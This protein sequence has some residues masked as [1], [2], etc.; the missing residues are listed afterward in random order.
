M[1]TSSSNEIRLTLPDS[2]AAIRLP[3][4]WSPL[5]QS[6]PLVTLLSPEGDLRVAFATLPTAAGTPEEIAFQTWRLFDASFAF[7]LLRKLQMPGSNGW[8]AVFQIF[9]DVPAARASTAWA[10]LRTLHDK[11]FI[12][13]IQGA[14]ASLSRR[15]AQISD[16]MEQWKPD[17]LSP[18]SLA[19]SPRR[20]WDEKLS[21]EL[22][23]FL[24]SAMT[25]RN[26]PGAALAVVQRG[27]IVFAEGF[28]SL[29]IASDAQVRPDTRFM[30]GSS[31][32]PLTTL[33]MA[34]LVAEG[35]FE[36]S[37]PVTQ[38]LPD[39]ALADAE[40]TRRLQMWHTVSASTGMPRRDLDL[41]FKFKGVTPE[42]RLAEMKEMKPTTGFGET[43]QY[44]NYLVGAG[45][46][47]AARSF[48]QQ[49]SLQEAYEQAMRE[50]VFEP[51]GMNRTTLE[52]E[53]EGVA[54]PHA[55]DFDGDVASL[56]PAIER[57][58][59]PI[60]PSGAVWST[61]IDMAQYLLLELNAG[62][63]R[64]GEQFLSAQALQKRWSGGARINDKASYGLGLL[65]SEYDGLDVMSHGGNTLGFSSD[66]YFLPKEEMG[67]VLLTNLGMANL[68]LEAARQKLFELLFDSP[69]KAERM[70]A[71]ASQAR[72]E[73]VTE[74]RAR[75]K[76]DAAS[77]ARLDM[78]TGEYESQELGPLRVRRKNGEYWAEFAS[79]SSASGLE[80]QPNGAML[81]VLT[82]APWGMGTLKLQVADEGRTL[83]L[84]GG[85]NVY[86]FVKRQLAR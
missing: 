50:L 32:K 59:K 63:L 39:F 79:W 40:L 53:G 35:R 62:T 14:K 8:D 12:T 51:L 23:R 34:R 29:S 17:G 18:R 10:I 13:L 33:M 26:V 48:R 27:R 28:G 46:Y 54:S 56:D 73:A 74:R 57:F 72:R 68:F 11:T 55:I 81:M 16:L 71:S 1:E 66:L 24:R 83:V 15:L 65:R 5:L 6:E 70:I 25:E 84:D 61:V 60:A 45:G 76:R 7:P 64:G 69:P 44:S 22:A 37:T 49:G 86:R 21:S 67:A 20:T 78:L 30:I 58:A 80:D 4:G 3:A 2:S 41:L 47:A 52:A 43:F 19:N 85:Q 77:V 9:Y 75:V 82:S 36:W 42:Q 38:L 31:T